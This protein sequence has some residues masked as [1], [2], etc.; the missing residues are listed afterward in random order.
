MSSFC[1][2]VEPNSINLGNSCASAH[3]P[4]ASFADAQ[5]CQC[6]RQIAMLVMIAREGRASSRHKKLAFLFGLA[7]LD[8]DF[9][10]RPQ[11]AN[12]EQQPFER[13]ALERSAQ[14]F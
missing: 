9:H 2:G 3:W 4:A 7:R 1:A 8:L 10:V 12:K 5:P 6:D 13:K 14:Q 11:R